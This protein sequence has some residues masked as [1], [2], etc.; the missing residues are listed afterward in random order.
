MP[1]LFGKFTFPVK[2]GASCLT[3]RG[4]RCG[5]CV[6]KWKWCFFLSLLT[7]VSRI[8]AV[9]IYKPTWES[10]NTHQVPEWL[11]DAK[12][13]IYAHWGLYSVPAYGNEWYGKRMYDKGAGNSYY[14]HHVQTYGNPAKFG[15]KD[16][17]PLFKAERYDP[18]EWS[19]IIAQSGARYAGFAVVHH[20]GFLL[21]DSAVNRWNAGNMG[22]KRD[23]YGE[24]VMALRAKG[25]KTIATFHHIRTF[26]W[27]LPS[28][29]ETIE[30]GR[31]EGWDLFDKRYA[32]LYWNRYVADYDDFIVEWQAKVKEV[33]DK[34]KPDLLWF[35]GGTFQDGKSVR[36]VRDI[37]SYYYNQG[38][39]WGK[40]VEIL[41]KLPSSMRW[42]FPREFGVLTFEEGRDRG[43]FVDRP[44]IDDQKISVNS[45]GYIEGQEYK[46]PNEIIDGLVD[47][48]ARGGGLLLSLCPK[49]DGTISD[50]QKWVL[51]EI[52]GWLK[53]NGDAIYGSRKWKVQVD[54]RHDKFRDFNGNHST[55]KFENST[56]EDIRFTRNGNKLYLF[57]LEWPTNGKV[58]SNALGGHAALGTGGGLKSVKLLGSDDKIRWEQTDDELI[59][60][61]PNAKPNPYAYAFEIEVKGEL[62]K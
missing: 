36:M 17:A 49:A 3:S 33:T 20:D 24:L 45:W 60:H 57:T 29:P 11:Q 2:L 44:W 12:F 54:G 16:F 5:C 56:A 40:E 10:L 26:D 53:Q 52:G 50:E 37:L 22:P 6:M 19:D 58:V 31:R 13:G 9:E 25:L 14:E 23:L 15:N 48:V 39:A 41:N 43:G 35:D 30:L 61:T 51:R 34:Y 18:E 8:E 46:D 27:Y 28:K 38:I 47:R 4:T 7:M 62:I 1:P 59:I 21:W 42:N 32:D 55:W